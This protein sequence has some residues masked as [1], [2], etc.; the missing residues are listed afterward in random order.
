MRYSRQIVH[1]QEHTGYHMKL[2]V[3]YTPRRETSLRSGRFRLG[4]HHMVRAAKLLLLTLHEAKVP[5]VLEVIRSEEGKKVAAAKQRAANC[6][7]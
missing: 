3:D 4:L 1:V 7:R 6:H 5:L 2:R